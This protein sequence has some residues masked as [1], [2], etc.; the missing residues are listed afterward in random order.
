MFPS[1]M[2]GFLVKGLVSQSVSCNFYVDNFCH[3][4]NN[5]SQKLDTRTVALNNSSYNRVKLRPRALHSGHK[6][7]CALGSEYSG[8]GAQRPAVQ[9]T[10]LG[11]SSGEG[12]GYCTVTAR[13]TNRSPH[14]R[15]AL[16]CS[17][18]RHSTTL[19]R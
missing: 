11:T 8:C 16:C 19:A 12:D 5:Y 9:Q 3:Q 4:Q 6:T 1:D 2:R 10:G 7:D 13:L 17:G 15:T 14:R 18:T